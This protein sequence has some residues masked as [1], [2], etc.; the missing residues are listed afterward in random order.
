MA[1]LSRRDIE[2]IF[3]AETDKATRPIAELGKAVKASRG[4][5]Q[6]LIDDA[7]KGQVSLEKLGAT[8]RDLKQ[9]QDELG[10]ARALLTSLNAQNAA[11]EKAA[12]RV[13]QAAQKYDDLKTRVAAA[14]KPT[15]TLTNQMAAAERAFNGAQEKLALVT[16]QAQETK[17][18]I[19]GIIGP[20][21]NVEASF[22]T[23]ANTSKEISRGLAVAGTAADEFKAKLAGLNAEQQ[24]SA[25]DA[26]FQ[27]SGKDA[28]L[29]QAQINYIS[30]FEN[31]VQ[32]LAQ[33][34]AELAAQNANFDKAVQAQEAKVGAANVRSLEAAFQ[35]AADAEARFKQTQAFQT[36]AADAK[37]AA[38]DV[39]RFG[40]AEDETAA[41]TVRFAQAIRTILDPV[42]AANASLA[43]AREQVDTLSTVLDGRG[44]KTLAEYN[45]AL[46][47]LVATGASIGR[48]AQ[49]ID[50]FKAQNQV[51]DAAKARFN[52]AQA[53]AVRLADAL[54]L[55]PPNADEIAQQLRKA[56]ANVESAGNAM[57]QE[58]AKLRKLGQA[59][60]AAGVDTNNL[61]AAE[62]HL[63]ETAKRASAAQDSI[64]KVSSGKAGGFLGLSVQDA[65]NL[66]YQLN[67]IFTQLA[68]GQ[69]I[70]ITLAQQG[71]QIWQIQ[72]IKNYVAGLGELLPLLGGVA[73][74]LGLVAAAVVGVY[75]A[76]DDK[77]SL[78]NAKAYVASL[79][80]QGTLTAQQMADAADTIESF[81]VKTED[82]TAI[83]RKFNED[84]LDPSYLGEYIQAAQ[85]ASQVTGKDF[86][87][88]A[89]ALTDALNG[90]YDSVQK[91][92]EVFPVLTD[93]EMAQIKAMYDSGEQDKARQ[94][95]F[96]RFTEKYQ[97]AADKMNGPWSNAW[98]NLKA[99]AKQFSD[100][101]GTTM[102]SALS[103]LRN[104][105]DDVA[106]G[107]NFVLLKLRGVGKAQA[108]AAYDAVKA[109]GGSEQ[110]AQAA[111]R[112][113]Q[114]K[115]A[116]GIAVNNQ[117]R[118]PTAKGRG[119]VTGSQPRSTAAGQAAIADARE[120]LD[121]NKKLTREQRIQNAQLKARREAQ[122]KGYGAQ[123][124]ATL[125]DLAGQKEAKAADRDAAAAAAAA[126]RKG[127]A[128]ARKAKA[129]S[130]KAQREAE[131]YQR[132]V[133]SETETLQKTME[134]MT[135]KVATLSAQT[136]KDQL[137]AVVTAVDAQYADTV[138]KLQAF[139]KLTKGKGTINGMSIADYQKT[140]DAN[141]QALV[142]QGQM[143]VY[144][145]N[146]NDLLKERKSLLADI[147]DKANRGQITSAEAIKQ[148]AEVTSKFAPLVDELVQNALAFAK[149]VAGAAPSA[150]TRAFIARLEGIK[151]SATGDNTADQK[152]EAT[153]RLGAE[154]AKLN[155]IIGQR[156][157]LVESY[158]T[159]AQL[160][161]I[162]DKQARQQS[163]D[164]FNAAKEAI[165][166]QSQVVRD[167]LEAGKASFD[168]QV[169]DAMIAK[170]QAVGAQ[171]EYLDPRFAQLKQSI[172]GIITDNIVNGI[173][174]VAQAAAR[175]AT[176]ASNAGDFFKEAG[177]AVLDFFADT[178][179]MIARLIIQMLVLSAVEKATGIPVGALLRAT[180]GGGGGGGGGGGFSLFGLK[181][182][183]GGGTVGEA[184]GMRTNRVQ[185]NPAALA[186]LPRYHSGTPAVGL[187]P[188]EQLAVVQ[189]GEKILTEEQQRQE[190]ARL[191]AAKAGGNKRGLRQVLA[192]GD[193]QVA[194]A[195]A[196]SAGEDV[197][198]THL[199]RNVPLLKQLV[200]E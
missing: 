165:L 48:I 106:T 100:F 15:K 113:T 49:S 98:L 18:Q 67:D 31:R 181:L 35:E 187:N 45:S 105:L 27:Q 103:N 41:S 22:R 21:D 4:Q 36:I 93:A 92:N 162:T 133:D 144:E 16:A 127:D 160:G 154:E 189:K 23:I 90:G 163:A 51:V 167:T 159:L 171:A 137:G 169:Y 26:A 75:A 68:S 97:D 191:D 123:D 34:K 111:F 5:L 151:N 179:R 57:A 39:S 76:T 112:G 158:N 134:T 63:T 85:N 117:G 152:A 194:A 104:N 128:A 198:V 146:V 141:K 193:D 56:E 166:A 149:S 99:A 180:D 129:A 168:P 94:L 42:G 72:G 115:I 178:L 110:E 197:T 124:V 24:K 53:E 9:A 131:A 37:A 173:D 65:T 118:A 91:L 135:A 2:M 77:Q 183:H 74:G 66:S 145:E 28:G 122:G 88:A 153:K 8:T 114:D 83:V 139:S 172:D 33:A 54:A 86:S 61:A 3:R 147:E 108:Q 192:F 73:G 175:L 148:T 184:G 126:K 116:G 14:E 161:L 29:L 155:T 120:L 89:G 59:L 190:A 60:K 132:K 87:E 64:R 70:F 157:A 81:G 13:E 102:A 196:G 143:K 43:G 82:A 46:N 52:E 12:A 17:A 71:P 62:E 185:F 109:R 11:V 95:I 130:D 140:L 79:G 58:E 188:T 101:L 10:S 38:L 25:S 47:G 1:A 174:R 78:T 200:N 125:A 107:I 44:R 84:G 138:R 182:F 20:V 30:Q 32:L 186:S 119:N 121:V 6:A 177:L 19:E 176:G 50:A 40:V 170:L 150:E 136:L 69:S 55:V 7:D 156:N 142:N 164:A 195:M 96:D 80:E 199:R